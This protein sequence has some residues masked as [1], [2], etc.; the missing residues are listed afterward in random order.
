MANAPSPNGKVTPTIDKALR[1]LITAAYEAGYKDIEYERM[2]NP[3]TS[4]SINALLGISRE[5]A[6]E[7]M[8]DELTKIATRIRRDQELREVQIA[9]F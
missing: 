9:R 2:K 5:S 7:V 6:N 1:V 8:I 3:K 4:F